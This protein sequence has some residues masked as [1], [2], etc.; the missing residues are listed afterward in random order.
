M[1][2]EILMKSTAVKVPQR[3]ADEA[4][5]QM[6]VLHSALEFCDDSTNVTLK[7]NQIG[8]ARLSVLTFAFVDVL[9]IACGVQVG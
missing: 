9:S 4:G 8:K 7:Y 3:A 6:R 5:S 1:K 2:K